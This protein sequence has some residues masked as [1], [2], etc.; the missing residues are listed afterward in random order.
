[1]GDQQRPPTDHSSRAGT[2]RGGYESLRRGGLSHSDA[3]RESRKASEQVHR[4]Q[5]KLN[6]DRGKR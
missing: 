2:E 5:D 1:M 6:S 4:V 3:A